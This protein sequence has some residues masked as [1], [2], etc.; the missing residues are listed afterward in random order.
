MSVAYIDSEKKQRL[1]DQATAVA[2]DVAAPGA[3]RVDA[4]AV[5]PQATFDALA[6]AGLLG[7]HVPERLGGHGEG[8]IGLLL[9]TETLAGACSSSGLCFG[10]HNVATA[11]LAA[12]AT[13]DHEERFLLPIARGKHVTSLAVSEAGTGSH[14]YLTDTS[15]ERDG[16]CFTVRGQKQFVSSGAQA[17]SYVTS[18]MTTTGRSAPG[19]FNMLVVEKD[20][21][22]TVWGEPW[23]GF[24]MRGN[25]ARSL[26]LDGARVNAR[27]LLGAEG[28]QT[29]YMF[30]IVVPYFIMA[31]AGTYLGIAQAA[32]DEAIA[33]VRTRRFA[34]SGEALAEAPLVQEKVARLWADVEKG[35][36]FIY[37][38]ARLGDAGDVRA[39]P[40]ILSAKAEMDEIAVRVT[41]EAMSLGGGIEYRENGKMAR[42]L[43]DARASQVMS[44]TTDLLR[45]W[46]GRALLGLPIL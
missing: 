2:M 4:E 16:D 31:M 42:L 29:W 7:L 38:A 8:L 44:P 17:D 19:E 20:T 40:A 28:D 26:K 34:H 15:I 32:L 18:T 10:M 46:T 3:D 37:H 11:V 33:H 27:N 5:W 30:E 25:A 12:K 9:T 1:R 6:E 21:P 41:N 39:L 45:L 14:L 23:K 36:R 24:G 43:R 13:P 35:R 22:G